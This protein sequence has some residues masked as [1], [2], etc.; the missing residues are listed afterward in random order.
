MSKILLTGSSIFEQWT[1][2]AKAVPKHQLVNRA[3]GGTTTPYWKETLEAVLT[4]EKPDVLWFY[5]GSNDLCADTVPDNVA[6]NVLRCREIARK[7]NPS[8][9]FAYF[10]II[11]APQKKGRWELIDSIH[12]DIR[13]QLPA[14]DLFV[15]LNEIFFPDGKPVRELFVEDELHL[16]GAAYDAMV[17]FTRPLIQEWL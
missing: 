15:D 13:N 1:N 3:I 10:S 7:H 14:E 4:E 16:T 2:A 9:R 6:D 11:K 8:M 17:K 5:C 12:A